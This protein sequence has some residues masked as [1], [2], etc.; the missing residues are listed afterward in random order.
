MPGIVHQSVQLA[1]LGRD[2]LGSSRYRSSVEN[3][4][5]NKV[6]VAHLLQL[7][8]SRSAALLVARAR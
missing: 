6:D 8:R 5:L 7:R 3:I 4:E 1:G 2:L